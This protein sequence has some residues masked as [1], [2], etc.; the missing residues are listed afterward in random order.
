MSVVN[1]A[2]D[3]FHKIRVKLYRNYLLSLKGSYVARTKIR[4][5]IR[6]NYGGLPA[7]VEIDV[8]EG[9]KR[10]SAIYCDD[11]ISIPKSMLTDFVGYLS[12][13]KMDEVANRRFDTALRI[14][15]AV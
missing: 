1:N 13:A 2:D 10:D 9:L 14:A 4:A 12:D 6:A 5:P 7:Q 11:L 3:L 15:L 8:N